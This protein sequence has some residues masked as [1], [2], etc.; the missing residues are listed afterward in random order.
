MYR[1]KIERPLFNS[2][3]LY[4]WLK[5]N[6]KMRVVGG[7]ELSSTMI[8]YLFVYGRLWFRFNWI[9]FFF[10]LSLLVKLHCRSVGRKMGI[11]A[12]M[13]DAWNSIWYL[14]KK[15]KKWKKKI[16]ITLIERPIRGTQT[17]RSRYSSCTR[18]LGSMFDFSLQREIVMYMHG[19]KVIAWEIVVARRN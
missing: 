16:E 17:S 12:R 10:L 15:N 13:I 5:E 19:D 18:S 6:R 7:N 4:A 2:V 3:F 9:I 14:P 8:Y 1:G 11:H